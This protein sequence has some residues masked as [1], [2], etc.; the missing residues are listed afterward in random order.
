M[1]STEINQLVLQ[2]NPGVTSSGLDAIVKSLYT[3]QK[4][5]DLLDIS[6]CGITSPI[7]SNT[8]DML[9]ISSARRDSKYQECITKDLR[10]CFNNIGTRNKQELRDRW[11]RG[12]GSDRA[13]EF[14]NE[15]NYILYI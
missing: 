15:N 3:E 4:Q 5:I 10:L 2:G 13:K 1:P 6:A 12:W 8:I 7:A 9:M 14:C 11:I